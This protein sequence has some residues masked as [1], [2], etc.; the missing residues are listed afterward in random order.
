MNKIEFAKL[1]KLL[2]K[3]QTEYF[4]DQEGPDFDAIYEL[5]DEAK[6]AF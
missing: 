5:I 1:E 4:G 6:N 3:L 2:G